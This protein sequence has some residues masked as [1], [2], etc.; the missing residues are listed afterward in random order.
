MCVRVNTNRYDDVCYLSSGANESTIGW[1]GDLGIT[2]TFTS[3]CP[4]AEEEETSKL[5][6]SGIKEYNLSPSLRINVFSSLLTHKTG[7]N[8]NMYRQP[9]LEIV[10]PPP[11]QA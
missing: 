10:S 6:T 7:E 11:R 9:V 3:A 1:L 8:D 5:K 2:F 4:L